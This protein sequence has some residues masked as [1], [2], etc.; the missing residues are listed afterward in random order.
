VKFCKK[1]KNLK[2]V[3]INRYIN[4][5][6]Y[7][8]IKYQYLLFLIL[9]INTISLT[10]TASDRLKNEKKEMSVEKK[11]AD[12][13]S[14]ALDQELF[15]SLK[16]EA[17]H[18]LNRLKSLK[19]EKQNIK[20]FDD[21]REKGLALFFEEQEKFDAQR[22]RGL[23]EFRN[24]RKLQHSQEGSP[25][26]QEFIKSQNQAE[27]KKEESRKVHI[28]TRNQVMNESPGLI[29]ELESSE[30]NLLSLRPRY[31]QRQR[32][33][34]KWLKNQNKSNG[35]GSG[36]SGSAPF[37]NDFNSGGGF[38]APSMDYS[39]PPPPPPADFYEEM[40]PPPPPPSYDGGMGGFGNGFD[41]G[42]FNGESMPSYPPQPQAPPQDWDF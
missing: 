25:A 10:S 34:N 2:L 6:V 28:A 22:D 40:P 42:G 23:R 31:D 32:G 9:A 18:N 33:R 21:E 27:L 36:S 39:P 1:L 29:A 12:R 20:I 30:M 7:Y 4:K 24:E 11:E 15:Q 19:Q 37:N 26:H 16:K 8:C 41:Q 38:P 17:H 14:I 13:K 3:I 35:T 5:H